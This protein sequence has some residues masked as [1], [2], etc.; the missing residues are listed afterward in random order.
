[1][2]SSRCLMKAWRDLQRFRTS[3]CIVNMHL[4]FRQ[5]ISFF[6]REMNIFFNE[7]LITQ[8][9]KGDDYGN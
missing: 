9:T 8:R 5:G 2:E 7:E 1:M 4:R 6:I 3:R